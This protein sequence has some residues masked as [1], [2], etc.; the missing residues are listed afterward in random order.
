VVARQANLARSLR[1]GR[2][3]RRPAYQSGIGR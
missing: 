2:Q 3:G 1:R